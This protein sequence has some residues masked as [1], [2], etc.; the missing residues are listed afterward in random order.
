MI[1]YNTFNKENKINY[2]SSKIL[3]FVIRPQV[4]YYEM[5]FMIQEY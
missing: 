3:F 1:L 2:H 5:L 4:I